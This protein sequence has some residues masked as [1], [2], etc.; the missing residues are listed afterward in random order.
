M[1][2]TVT[3][4]SVH[5]G[6]TNEWSGRCQAKRKTWQGRVSNQAVRPNDKHGMVGTVAK[7][8]RPNGK[9][10]MIGTVTNLSG[11]MINMACVGSSGTKSQYLIG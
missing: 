10:G 5:I 6:T 11:Q 9:H 1:V 7:S 4:L 2:G 3:N 8:V